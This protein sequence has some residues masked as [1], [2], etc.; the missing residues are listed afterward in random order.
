[1]LDNVRIGNQLTQK[2]RQNNLTQEELAEQLGVSV[3]TISKWENGHT[4]PETATLP[5]L[6]SLFDCSIDTIL[7]PHAAQDAA[8]RDYA[9]TIGGQP[10]E[11][12]LRL[13]QNMRS[14]FDFTV[15]LGEK[16]Q[17]WDTV[18]NS[19]SAAFHQAGSEYFILRIDVEENGS[20]AARLPLPNCAQY[21]HLVESMP[22]HI[23][24]GFRYDDCKCCRQG[25]CPV[26]MHYT[27]EGV[28]YRQC[29]FLGIALDSV[30]NME[31]TFALL[32]A[33]HGR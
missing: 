5:L 31:H 29:H 18:I 6:A 21:M 15:K 17:I 16:Y 26:R 12:V 2:R 23:K 7:R 30:E 1:M 22:E 4:L 11:L 28:E 33:E 25:G 20:A 27:F 19:N 14:K 32:C 8:F 24:R 10:G 13:Y 3:Q 9:Q